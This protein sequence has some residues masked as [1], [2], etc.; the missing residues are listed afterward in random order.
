MDPAVIYVL[1]FGVVAFLVIR[2]I[3]KKRNPPEKI[4]ATRA[5]AKV[6]V[7]KEFLTDYIKEIYFKAP[8]KCDN[9]KEFGTAHFEK[10]TEVE[11]ADCP[12]CGLEESVHRLKRGGKKVTP[13]EIGEEVLTVIAE[14]VELELDD[15]YSWGKIARGGLFDH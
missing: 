12:W 2:F 7:E 14:R 5:E 10:G 13:P 15:M 6:A 11:E 4:Y 3:Q 1:L 9:C 8:V